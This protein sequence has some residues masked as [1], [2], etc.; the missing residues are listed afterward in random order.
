M[1]FTTTF[2]LLVAT[3][4]SLVLFL[5]CENLDKSVSKTTEN[6]VLQKTPTPKDQLN[7]NSR[8]PDMSDN[9][10]VSQGNENS[11]PGSEKD[12]EIDDVKP[13]PSNTTLGFPH[14]LYGSFDATQKGKDIN[15]VSVNTDYSTVKA[16]ADR[17]FNVMLPKVGTTI[18]MDMMNCYGYLATVKVEYH[19]WQQGKLWFAEIMPGTPVKDIK[20]RLLKCVDDPKDKFT[21]DYLSNSVYF[22]SPA[23]N[24]R[25]KVKNMRNPNW[26]Q[27]LELVPYEWIKVAKISRSPDKEQIDNCISDWLD[28]DGDGTIDIMSLCVVNEES[29]TES[30]NTWQYS[31]IIQ[32]VDG[33]WRQVW[34]VGYETKD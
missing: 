12:K 3:L 26:K 29:V 32:L 11:L 23:S 4:L 25:Q 18:R 17:G 9:P 27:V 1:N 10:P 24:V 2:K 34:Q 28:S 8:T 13:N 5:A 22:I 30:G 31:R 21:L 14:L 6:G 19:G 15:S 7:S 16:T 20:N 33:N